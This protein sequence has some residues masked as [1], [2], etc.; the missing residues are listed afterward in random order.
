MHGCDES[1]LGSWLFLL[2]SGVLMARTCLARTPLF[3]VEGNCLMAL[4]TY[5]MLSLLMPTMVSLLIL[6]IPF[7]VTMPGAF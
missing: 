3:S 2:V 4:I 7:T 5:S 1:S 6:T